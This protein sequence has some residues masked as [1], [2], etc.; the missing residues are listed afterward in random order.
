LPAAFLKE[1]ESRKW[2]MDWR[3][4]VFQAEI[5]RFAQ[6]DRSSYVVG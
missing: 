6:D 1:V 5:L 3:R 4:C 2:E